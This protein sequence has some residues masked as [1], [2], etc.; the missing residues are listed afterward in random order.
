MSAPDNFLW[1]EP[2]LIQRLTDQ[3][4][5]LMPKV[6]VLRAADL[7][8]VMEEKQVTPAV[9]L[10]YRGYRVAQNN[11]GNDTARIEQ[12][13][14]AIVAT[15]NMKAMRTG[16]AARADAGVIAQRVLKALMGYSAPGTSK[17]LR[18]AEAPEAGFNAG[19]QYLPL[20]FVAELA[21][22]NK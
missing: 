17:P 21:V 4:G 12:I 11:H 8:G 14:L 5:S 7:E 6:K 10:V 22:T 20:G 13:W 1:L 16:E 15:R 9:H 2:L 19:F 18:L 3:L